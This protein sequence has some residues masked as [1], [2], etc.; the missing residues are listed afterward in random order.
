MKETPP[1]VQKALTFEYPHLAKHAQRK[2]P[3]S[4][5]TT[6]Y[7]K[8]YG[9]HS[10]IAARIIH[11]SL[12]I[13]LLAALI[14]SLGGFAL[15]RV[16]GTLFALA[17]LVIL[18]PAL[19]D[20]IGDFGTVVA[21]R[22][23]AMLHE[24]KISAHWAR[25]PE[26]RALFVQILASAV[27][28][29]LLASAAAMALSSITTGFDAGLDVALKI[30]AITLA[31]VVLLVCLI[32]LISIFAGL[33]FYRKGEDP[34]NFLIPIVTSVADFVNIIVLAALVMVFF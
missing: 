16:K 12:R 32:F 13:L 31:D 10:H 24:G 25:N 11:E 20:M 5:K 19:N 28:V 29:S 1:H 23:S 17:P 14:S 2:M 30:A 9:P 26:L 8:E 18:L 6:F 22:F 7:M 21:G 15:E 33:H 4:H 3:V 34:N 27:I